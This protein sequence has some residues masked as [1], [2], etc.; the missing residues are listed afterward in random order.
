MMNKMMGGKKPAGMK[1]TMM[2]EGAGKM[3]RMGKKA[4]AKGPKAVPAIGM[5]SGGMAMK[6]SKKPSK[7]DC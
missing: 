2:P 5:S 4:G 7:K 6:S 1:K 3:G